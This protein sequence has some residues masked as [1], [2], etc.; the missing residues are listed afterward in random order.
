MNRRKFV[1]THTQRER[2]KWQ[3]VAALYL[4]QLL[5]VR[6]GHSLWEAEFLKMYLHWPICNRIKFV[7]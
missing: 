6:S 3:R 7:L 4:L 1:K 5:G 2:G